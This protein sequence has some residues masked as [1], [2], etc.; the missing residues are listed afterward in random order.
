[1]LLPGSLPLIIDRASM[2]NAVNDHEMFLAKDFVNDSIV[3]LTKF[4]KPCKIT[5]QGLRSDVLN[6]LSQ[7]SNAVYNA[8]GD[9]GIES[10]QLSAGALEDSRSE[11]RLGQPQTA[12]HVF[13]E[14]SALALGHGSLLP[15]KPFA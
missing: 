3:A 9:G 8:A 1:M 11:H 4:E 13:Q 7:P 2:A 15:Q 6:V 10:L 14:F 5:F 12:Y